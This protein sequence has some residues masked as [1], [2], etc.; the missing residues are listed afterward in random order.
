MAVAMALQ[1]LSKTLRCGVEEPGKPDALSFAFRAHQVHAVV[2][3]PVAH[4]R[5][6]VRAQLPAMIQRAPA[7]LPK[8]SC[9]SGNHGYEHALVLAR[10]QKRALDEVHF[11]IEYAGVTCH[12]DILRNYVRKPQEIVRAKRTNAITRFRM[13]P[14]LRIAFG[15]LACRR[16]QNVFPSNLWRGVQKRHGILQ[17]IAESESS[18]RLI[19]RGPAPEPATQRLIQQPAVQEM[20]SR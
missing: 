14:M 13:P 3:V 16:H 15:E 10:L 1:Q 18:A 4:E 8:R 6:T 5:Q 19:Q 20:V 17:L 12:A 11:F 7:V 9:L 2:P